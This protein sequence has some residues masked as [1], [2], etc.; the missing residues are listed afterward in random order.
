VL[1]ELLERLDDD[2]GGAA[3]WLLDRGLAP[4]ELAALRRRL[5]RA[6]PDPAR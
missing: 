3:A 1:T 2:H 4:S 5:L 6:N